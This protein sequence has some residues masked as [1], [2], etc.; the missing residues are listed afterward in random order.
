MV[1]VAASSASPGI[2]RVEAFMRLEE[3]H[4]K[5]GS[6]FPADEPRGDAVGDLEAWG[7]P[8]HPQGLRGAVGACAEARRPAEARAPSA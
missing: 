6:G 7:A 3:R 5:L 1:F 8:E 2:D 4:F